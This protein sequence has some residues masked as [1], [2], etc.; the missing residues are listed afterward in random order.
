MPDDHAQ[1]RRIHVGNVGQVEDV[2]GRRLA[3]GQHQLQIEQLADGV[4]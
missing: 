3:V 1:A 2:N 4:R